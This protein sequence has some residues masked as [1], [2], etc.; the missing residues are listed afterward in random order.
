MIKE[1]ADILKL[2]VGAISPANDS[3][4]SQDKGV[5]YVED[6]VKIDSDIFEKFLKLKELKFLYFQK[7]VIFEN[8]VFDKENLKKIQLK[9]TP[10]LEFKNCVFKNVDLNS[11]EFPNYEKNR[12]F[13]NCEF[14]NIDNFLEFASKNTFKECVY[15]S[16]FVA[17]N[18]HIDEDKFLPKIEIKNWTFKGKVYLK[19]ITCNKEISFE[20]INFNGKIDFS[21]STFEKK[22][23]FKKCKFNELNG[24]DFF[25]FSEIHFKDN[26]Y[27]DDSYFNEFVAFHL[28]VFEKTASFYKTKFK[29]I[30]N[31]SPGDFKGILNINNATWVENDNLEF[32]DVRSIVKEA[33]GKSEKEEDELEKIRN[34]KDSFR[35]IKNVLIQKNNLL[36]AQKFHKAELYCEELRIKQKVFKENKTENKT[37]NKKVI[38]CSISK[39]FINLIFVISYILIL[40]FIFVLFAVLIHLYQNSPNYIQYTMIDLKYLFYLILLVLSFLFAIYLNSLVK[41][42][43]S[44]DTESKYSEYKICVDYILLKTYSLTSDHHTNFLKIFNFTISIIV[45]FGISTLLL[46]PPYFFND[47][48]LSFIQIIDKKATQDDIFF[49]SDA[50]ITSVS[51]VS[52]L[53]VFIY[54]IK[55]NIHND[56]NT[57]LNLFV[58]FFM[59]I[60]L[61]MFWS[62]IFGFNLSSISVPAFFLFFIILIC[63]YKK[64]KRFL[65]ACS[66]FAIILILAFSP[67][68]INPFV[69]VFKSD[70]LIFK[71]YVDEKLNDLNASQII[72]IALL[73]QNQE[74]I[75]VTINST[76]I[77]NARELIK[78]NL[79]KDMKDLNQAILYRNLELNSTIVSLKAKH[80]YQNVLESAIKSSSLVYS[81]I[82]LLCL[83][84]LTKT[85]RKNSI[86][87][88]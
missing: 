79:A 22:V 45:L 58:I 62:M 77:I 65:I 26:V 82:L 76:E 8:C 54:I 87:P 86:V 43:N 39:I 21:K 4:F 69:G 57:S 51:F 52:N 17:Y 38:F 14:E 13:L 60:I 5:Y 75:P 9:D 6:K 61:V 78:K 32:E 85:A 44:L 53:F 25:D 30:P 37:E 46:Y 50:I 49:R 64:P 3:I 18:V 71:N 16:D 11:L 1:I 59:L 88:I 70:S 29:V 81:I 33:Y 74:Q 84:S 28:C 73:L 24:D 19:N 12:S 80:T 15:E 35:A 56:K 66:Y 10:N 40:I 7:S 36:E 68:L 63:I 41:A 55:K 42:F 72:D 20:N 2:D 47:Y 83:Y 31:F 34:I 23:S 48:I 27:F 67:Q